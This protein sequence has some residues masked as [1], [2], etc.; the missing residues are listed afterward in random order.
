MKILYDYQAFQMQKVGGVSN[1]FAELIGHLPSSV[2]WRIGLKE[3]DNVHLKEKGLMS[4]LPPSS[5]SAENFFTR[6]HFFGKGT[7]YEWFNEHFDSFPSADH[8][9]K[10]Y[11]IEL[12]KSQF[13]TTVSGS[14]LTY[15]IAV[16]VNRVPSYKVPKVTVKGKVYD[17]AGNSVSINKTFNYTITKK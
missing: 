13:K 17:K 8:K 4:N 2:E 1:C 5:L 10:K 11:S 12:L 9:N 7:L 14:N 3:S 15:K 16:Q 6:K